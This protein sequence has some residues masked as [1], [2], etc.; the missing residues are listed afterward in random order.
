M[1]R[2]S[3]TPSSQD[4][5]DGAAKPARRRT[6]SATKRR[7]TEAAKARHKRAMEKKLTPEERL[8]IAKATPGIQREEFEEVIRQLLTKPR[9]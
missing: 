1:T 9:K 7:T 5:E 3:S 8:R 2:K 4:A 6:S